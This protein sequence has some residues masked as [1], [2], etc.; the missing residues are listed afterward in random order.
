[1]YVR[2][3]IPG[4]FRDQLVPLADIVTPNPFELELLTGVAPTT[5]D[6][7]RAAARALIGRGPSLVVATGLR[8]AE[9]PRQL[10]VLAAARDEAWVVRHPQRAVR[11][12]GTGDAFAAL[13]LGAYLGRRDARAALEH[14]V[15]ALDEVLAVA[16]ATDADELPLALAQDALVHPRAYFPSERLG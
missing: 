6:A 9:V 11:V 5:L 2:E 1:V 16:E 4:A 12:W 13:F 3:G 15:A 8:L 10:A 7:A 14:A